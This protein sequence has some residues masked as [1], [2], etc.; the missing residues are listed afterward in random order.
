[1]NLIFKYFL[2]RRAYT[3]EQM[4]AFT[5]QTQFQSHEFGETGIGFNLWL[6]KGQEPK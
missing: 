1:M 3:R 6:K 5:A 4:E 2:R